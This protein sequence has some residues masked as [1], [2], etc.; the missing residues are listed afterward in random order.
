[1]TY[2]ILPTALPLVIPSGLEVPDGYAEGSKRAWSTAEDKV[3]AL[4]RKHPDRFPLY[5]TGGHW[6]VEGDAWT[7]W[8]EGFL[9]GQLW[10]LAE[11]TGR[12]DLRE[13]AEHYSR[14]IEERKYDRTVHDLGFLFWSTWR[15][16]YEATGSE[17]LNE[18]VVQAG[19]TMSL[20][21]NE[22]GRYLRSF[23]AADSLFIDIMMNVGIIFYAAQQTGDEDLARIA[24]EHCLTTRRTLVRG[25]GSASHEGIFD[26][27]TGAFL[28]QTTQQGF[29]DDGSWAR[30]QGWAMYGFGTAY[31]HTGDRRFL[32]TAQDCADFYIE[33][34]GAALVPPNDWQERNPVHPFESSAAA[35][36][37]GGMWQL[38]GLIED[39]TRAR[40]YA[41]YALR[42]LTR[43][44]EPDFLSYGD[45]AWEGVLQHGSYHEGKGLGVDESVMWGDYWFLDALDGVDRHLADLRDH[46]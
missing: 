13:L 23:L 29:S 26:L 32:R 31:R 38:A 41:N 16:W 42:I 1:M 28:R 2:R 22:K 27:E 45:P 14:L 46:N 10:M 35:I 40:G 21:F 34:T 44:C 4:V 5:T 6:Q 3:T 30:G 7:N 37:A 36:A 25:D 18:T 9:G 15:R 17:E 8:C 33:R 19:R 24:Y 12:P 39:E 43:L 11:R 20:R